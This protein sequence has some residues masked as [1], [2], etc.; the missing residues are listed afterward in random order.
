LPPHIALTYDLFARL[1]RQLDKM[2]DVWPA[3]PIVI[4]VKDLTGEDSD[5]IFA[6]LEHKDRIREIYV[7]FLTRRGSQNW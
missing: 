2:L 5:I 6:A 4:R 1:E 7:E 3:L